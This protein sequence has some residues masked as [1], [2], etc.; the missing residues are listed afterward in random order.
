MAKPSWSNLADRGYIKHH[1]V[2]ELTRATRSGSLKSAALAAGTGAGW[3]AWSRNI[4][5]RN[6]KNGF[7]KAFSVNRAG[8]AIKLPEKLRGNGFG[9]S[10]VPVFGRTFSVNRAGEATKVHD[11]RRVS[12]P[13]KTSSKPKVDQTK[14]SET[15]RTFLEG[16]KRAAN[17]RVTKGAM[18][19]GVITGVSY[20]G[21][22]NTLGQYSSG[23]KIGQ[24]H[25]GPGMGRTHLERFTASGDVQNIRIEPGHGKA[26][27]AKPT[28][29]MYSRSRRG[30]G[31]GRRLG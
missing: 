15:R 6:R 9:A 25:G 13:G 21:G 29:G 7:A 5:N 10:S 2:P 16:I 4:K 27:P 26:L 20:S 14:D 23:L 24:F 31:V 17:S 8:E 18:G 19:P 11:F 22:R 12:E 28:I 1:H 30:A 3:Y